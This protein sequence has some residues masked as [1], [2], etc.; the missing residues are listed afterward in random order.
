MAKRLTRPIA[1]V[2][3]TAGRIAKGDLGSRIT[4]RSSTLEIAE[5]TDSVNSMAQELSDQELLRKRLTADVAHELRTP[6]ATLQ[7]HMEAMIDGIWEPEQDRLVSCH[8]EILRLTKLVGE[9]ETLSRYEGE[10]LMLHKERFELSELI[11]RILLNF[12][13]DFKTK[14]V[15]LEFGGDEVWV[16]ADRDKIS[17]VMVNLISNALKYTP[18]GGQVH[19]QTGE[20]QSEA[21]VTV[22]D[23]G[24]GIP[25]SDLPYIFERFY[26]TDKSRSRATGGSGIGLTIAKSII[27]A[28]SGNISVDSKVNLGSTFTVSLPKEIIIFI[29]TTQIIGSISTNDEGCGNEANKQ[30][31]KY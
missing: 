10:N 12:E 17:Q 4:E 8:E 20:T 9:L 29:K 28:H 1:S 18:E 5:L 25:E 31:S 14:G 6:L 11:K 27:D 26:R 13:N 22:S 23:T 16:D 15:F 3:D 2:I 24:I 7:S 19:V 21:I 30:E